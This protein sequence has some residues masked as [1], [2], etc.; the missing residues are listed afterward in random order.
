M[1][2]PLSQLSV[3]ASLLFIVTIYNV[4][5]VRS[6]TSV[7]SEARFSCYLCIRWAMEGTWEIIYLKLLLKF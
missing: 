5:I 3:V 4:N 1:S 7:Y 2:P 6:V